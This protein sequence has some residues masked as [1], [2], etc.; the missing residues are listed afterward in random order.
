MFVSNKGVQDRF[1]LL[2]ICSGFALLLA[3]DQI[4]WP[5]DRMSYNPLQRNGSGLF[6]C[7]W[8]YD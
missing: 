5:F 2:K 7:V 6:L 8:I 1:C 4:G 3:T